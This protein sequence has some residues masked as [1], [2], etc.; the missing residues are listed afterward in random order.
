MISK[1]QSIVN[2]ARTAADAHASDMALIQNSRRLPPGFQTESVLAQFGSLHQ[3]RFAASLD[4]ELT[5]WEARDDQRGYQPHQ[6]IIEIGIVLADVQSGQEVTRISTFVRPISNPTLS[7]FCLRLTGITQVD[8]DDAVP[9]PEAFSKIQTLLP[10][11]AKYVFASFGKDPEWLHA[12][13]LHKDP[14]A[15]ML[16]DPRYINVG[17]MHKLAF[18]KHAGGMKKALE[19]HSLPQE[20][21]HHRALPDALGV[22]RLL[23]SMKLSPLDALVSSNTTYSEQIEHLRADRLKHL[24]RHSPIEHATAL[25]LL[26]LVRWDVQRAREIAK[27]FQST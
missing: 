11:P 15:D 19:L 16:F 23:E 18:G 2:S 12:E 9:L 3:K 5:C 21:P 8:V 17:L 20:L 10:E 7:E 26:D 24:L 4:L 13:I 1:D 6:E 22:H 14:R 27:L 25:K